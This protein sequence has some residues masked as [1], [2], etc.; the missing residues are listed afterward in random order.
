[1]AYDK[2]KGERFEEGNDAAVTHGLLQQYDNLLAS[3]DD[4]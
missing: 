3:L 1:M 4:D 2:G